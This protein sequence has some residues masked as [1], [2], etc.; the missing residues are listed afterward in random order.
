[1]SNAIKYTASGGTITVNI[2]QLDDQF[3]RLS[4]TDTGEGISEND[5]ANLFQPFFRV[6][7]QHKSNVKG[8]GLGLSIVKQLVELQGGQISVESQEGKGTTFHVNLPLEPTTASLTTPATKVEKRILV[9]DDD[10]DILEVVTDRLQND[11]YLVQS[12]DT[13][14]G[15]LQALEKACFDGVVLDIGLPDMTGV[16]VLQTIRQQ[17]SELPVVMMTASEAQDRAIAAINQGANAYLLKPFDAAQ[18][19]YVTTQW[20]GGGHPTQ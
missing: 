2:A 12:A 8:L 6:N 1:M 4:V 3:A 7:R 10:P 11:G 20:F 16:Q 5:L 15:A 17:H 13:G 19:K 18:F 9:V 14:Y